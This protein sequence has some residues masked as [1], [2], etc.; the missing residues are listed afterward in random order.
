MNRFKARLGFGS[1]KKLNRLCRLG[2]ECET[3][4]V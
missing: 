2:W 4:S 3:E 1:D